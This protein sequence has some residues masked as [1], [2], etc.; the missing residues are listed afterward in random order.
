VLTVKK[1]LLRIGFG[2]TLLAVSLCL[3]PVVGAALS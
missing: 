2:C 3:V 1:R